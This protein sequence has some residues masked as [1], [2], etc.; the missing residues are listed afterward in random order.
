MAV[1]ATPV[2]DYV[3]LIREARVEH[4]ISLPLQI[5]TFIGGGIIY[6]RATTL[7]LRRSD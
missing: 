6:G 3:H 4:N 1:L 7:T 2:Q 5:S